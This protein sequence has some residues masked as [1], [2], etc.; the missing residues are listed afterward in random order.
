MNWYSGKD[1]LDGRDWTKAQVK[2]YLPV[3]YEADRL[4]PVATATSAGFPGP[5]W[6]LSNVLALEAQHGR[7]R[8]PGTRKPRAIHCLVPLIG[9]SPLPLHPITLHVL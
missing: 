4:L 9:G 5:Q 3:G 2:T 8:P 1:L 6:K 7:G